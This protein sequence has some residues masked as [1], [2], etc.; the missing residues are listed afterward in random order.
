MK[1]FERIKADI[2]VAP[3]CI[4]LAANQHLWREITVRQD[5]PGSAHHDTQ[6]IWL[7]GPQQITVD[8]VFNDL[9]AHDYAAMEALQP[10]IT[11]LITPLLREIGVTELGR[12][13]IVNLKAGGE[14]DK[15]WDDGAYA[16]HYSRFHLVLTSAEGNRFDCGDES[17]HMQQGE[18]WWFDHRSE[19]CVRNDSKQGR[20]HIIIDAVTPRYPVRVSEQAA[21]TISGNGIVQLGYD[22]AMRDAMPLL[23]EHW[24]EVAKNKQL[25][26]LKPDDESYRRIEAEGKLLILGAYRDGKMVGYS[27]NFVHRHLHYA[28]LIICQN[29]VLFLHKEHRSS[30]FG[31]QL[32]RS[33]ERM[34]KARG[35]QMMLWHAKQDTALD[36]LMPRLNYGV[37]DI[38]YSKEL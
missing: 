13:M 14:I 19:H 26:V 29:D 36:K 5:W 27:A 1:Y 38:I 18:L 25:M 3:I 2:D 31:L 28:D 22:R 15:H 35:A 6:C 4:A 23:T 17:V 11:Q 7:R 30:L 24:E 21:P 33:T 16:A 34:A 32:I 9:A 37:Q 20:I 10:E 12:V 8:A